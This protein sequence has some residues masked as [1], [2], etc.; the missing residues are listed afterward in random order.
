MTCLASVAGSLDEQ[1]AGAQ[2]LMGVVLI[3]SGCQ[4]QKVGRVQ[5]PIPLPVMCFMLNVL[6]DRRVY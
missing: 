2:N 1:R 3:T 5:G 4:G 6:Q